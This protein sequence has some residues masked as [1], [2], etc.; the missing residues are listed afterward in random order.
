MNRSP[1]HF[2]IIFYVICSIAIYGG[3]FGNALAFEWFQSHNS[4]DV[5]I[6][7]DK[8]FIINSID[9]ENTSHI[10][11][12]FPIGK[13]ALATAAHIVANRKVGDFVYISQIP[14]LNMYVQWRVGRISEINLDEDSAIIQLSSDI[15]ITIDNM[16]SICPTAPKEGVVLAMIMVTLENDRVAGLGSSHA[17]ATNLQTMPLLTPESNALL[18]AS[19]GQFPRDMFGKSRIVSAGTGALGESGGAMFDVNRQCV[20]GITSMKFP[21]TALNDMKAVQNKMGNP[22]FYDLVIGSPVLKYIKH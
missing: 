22:P 9:D 2:K 7:R 1:T 19:T 4:E 15:S 16:P 18:G 13:N 5:A 11:L 20:A 14:K 6:L 8:E 3:L 17:I 21:M 12:S 10:G